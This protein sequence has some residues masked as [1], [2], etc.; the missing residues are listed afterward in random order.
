[1]FFPLSFALTLPERQEDDRFDSE[2]LEYGI[3]GSEELL[4]CEVEEEEGVQGQ[5]DADVIDQSDVNV[6][7]AGT[8]K[9]WEREKN[10]NEKNFHQN[11]FL[12]CFH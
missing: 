3:E 9:N 4:G 2:E 12:L 1:M 5:G 10:R 11:I 6:A 8:E 7:L